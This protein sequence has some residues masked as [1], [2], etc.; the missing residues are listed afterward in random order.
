MECG[1]TTYALPTSPVTRNPGSL[2][3]ERP[4]GTA[5]A[6]PAWMLGAV[7]RGGYQS[8]DWSAPGEGHCFVLLG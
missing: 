1:G 8:M 2:I 6:P 7:W 5:A 3:H 4:P